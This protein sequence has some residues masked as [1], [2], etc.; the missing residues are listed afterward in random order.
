MAR[1]DASGSIDLRRGDSKSGLLVIVPM[2]RST[3]AATMTP[4]ILYMRTERRG[5]RRAAMIGAALVV[6]L[7]GWWLWDETPS[8]ESPSD[9]ATRGA[10]A[11]VERSQVQPAPESILVPAPAVAMPSATPVPLAPAPIAMPPVS[12][13]STMTVPIP[14]P[15]EPQLPSLSKRDESEPEG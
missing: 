15:A 7:G 9:A 2:R 1:G 8:A 4:M 11:S 5:L 13:E 12:E 3:C 14:A 10:A 6:V